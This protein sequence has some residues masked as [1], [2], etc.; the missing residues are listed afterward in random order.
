[1]S[2]EGFAVPRFVIL[3]VIIL[4]GAI[5]IGVYVLNN[6]QIFR[7]RATAVTWINA[8]KITN[9]QDK[10]LICDN[11]QNPPVCQTDT[12]AIKIAVED[13]SILSQS[14]LAEA[15]DSAN[16]DT[17]DSEIVA[18]EQSL[19]DFEAAEPTPTPEP[20]SILP[21]SGEE[22][23]DT[24]ATASSTLP[25]RPIG[26]IAPSGGILSIKVRD[27]EINFNTKESITLVLS[28]E[29]GATLATEEYD[30]P[31]VITKEDNSIQALVIKFN[32]QPGGGGGEAT[33]SATPSGTASSSATPRATAAA[34]ASA[35]PRAASKF[36]LN[37]DG[38]LNTFDTAS[39][40]QKWRGRNSADLLKI[41]FNSDGVVNIFDY[42]IM[43]GGLSG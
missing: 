31:I 26:S 42:S 22:E 37:G 24:E 3:I 25:P 40:L 2:Q 6:P 39:F 41:D 38:V 10:P 19:A 35:T 5:A 7:T 15:T 18:L 14:V 8:F 1:M 27:Q 29:E 36:D 16:M 30:I 23:E 43:K 21:S 9:A 11:S 20:V 34:S 13:L 32:Y 17:E 4:I 33:A 12:I 28:T